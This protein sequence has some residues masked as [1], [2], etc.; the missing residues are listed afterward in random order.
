M[1]G[2][3]MARRGR[4]SPDTGNARR[5]GAGARRRGRGGGVRGRSVGRVVPAG[6]AECSHCSFHSSLPVHHAS[7]APGALRDFAAIVGRSAFIS[8]AANLAVSPRGCARLGPWWTW[9]RQSTGPFAFGAGRRARRRSK[10]W[11]NRSSCGTSGAV[12]CRPSGVWRRFARYWT[13]N[14]TSGPRRQTGAINEL[15]LEE[16]VESTERALVANGITLHPEAKA[17]AVPAI[18]ELLDRE[19]EP[20]MAARVK[21]LIE[22]FAAGAGR[23]GR[24]SRLSGGAAFRP[25]C[26]PNR[27]ADRAQS[28][29]TTADMPMDEPLPGCD[30]GWMA[31]SCLQAS[32]R[33]EHRLLGRCTHACSSLVGAAPVRTL[34]SPPPDHEEEPDAIVETSFGQRWSWTP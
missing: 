25:R 3:D 9:W 4:A 11:G 20:A 33:I 32:N 24:G 12:G 8:R 7:P 6:V 5:A 19:R 15:R 23:A 31:G 29:R 21:R 1:D 27:R 18:Y 16:A 14:S 26:S 28:L 2:T 22:A 17:R 13:S 34:S 10:R 30:L